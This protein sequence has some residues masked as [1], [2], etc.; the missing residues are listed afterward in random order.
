MNKPESG[1]PLFGGVATWL[2]EQGLVEAGVG[3]ITQGLGR[4][5]VNGGVSLHRISIGGVILH[6][7]FGGLDVVWEARNDRLRTDMYRRNDMNT[8]DFQDSP[9][10]HMLNNG[11]PF[12][13]YRLEDGE[14]DLFITAKDCV[15]ADL[16]SWRF[17]TSTLVSKNALGLHTAGTVI[18]AQH[19]E[20]RL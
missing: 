7:V 8:P 16:D 9:F 14:L 2:L 3:E 10:F 5:L 12:M 15:V 6:P 18:F 20:I 13:R 4:R 17:G 19:V 1:S 11:I